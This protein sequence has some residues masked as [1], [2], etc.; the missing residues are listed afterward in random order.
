MLAASLFVI[1]TGPSHS[2]S[3]LLRSPG[4][5][6]VTGVVTGNVAGK[7]GGSPVAGKSNPMPGGQG[8]QGGWSG[9]ARRTSPHPAGAGAAGRAVGVAKIEG[10]GAYSD[11]KL[12]LPG[13]LWVTVWPPLQSLGEAV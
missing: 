5:C 1:F 12:R 7:Q 13:T 9:L 2:A 11:R 6:W 8:I 10:G 3:A 4:A